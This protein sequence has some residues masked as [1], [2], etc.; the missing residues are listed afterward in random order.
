M[1]QV[2]EQEGYVP[3]VGRGGLPVDIP[4]GEQKEGGGMESVEASVGSMGGGD[5]AG[6]IS[7][8]GRKRSKR[9]RGR[10]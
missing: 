6:A 4:T 10:R 1:S 2:R 8:D 3:R 7:E 9:M 5:G